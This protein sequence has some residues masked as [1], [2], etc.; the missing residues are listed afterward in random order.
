MTQAGRAGLFL[1]LPVIL[2]IGFVPARAS[3]PH[4]L[5]QIVHGRCV[6]DERL[7]RSPA[8]CALVDDADGFA[9]LK[10]RRGAEQFLLIPTARL[11]GIESPEILRAGAPNYFADAWAQIPLVEAQLHRVLPREDMSL[12][13]NS[14]FGR[15]QDQLHIHIDCIG[16]QVHDALAAELASI[17]T[18]WAD[19]RTPLA[20]HRYRAMRITGE[21]LGSVNPFRLLAASLAHP[22]REMRWHTLVLVGARLPGARAPGP[23]FVLLDGQVDLLRLDRASGEELQDHSCALARPL[24]AQPDPAAAHYTKSY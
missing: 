13:I 4:A 20:G 11:R 3:D 22:A 19:L 24:A 15:S 10:D 21:R 18:N 6:P 5:W 1:F 14:P 8:P 7:H 12:A 9:V 2:L 23:G 17:G 16:P